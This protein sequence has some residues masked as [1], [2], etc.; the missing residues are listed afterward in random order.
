M[1]PSKIF[2]ILTLVLAA[3]LYAQ[4][5]R[6]LEQEN[7]AKTERRLALVVGNGAYRTA[8]LKNPTNDAADMARTLSEM[9]FVVIH[10]ENLNL[11][12]MKR[13]VRD[14]GARLRRD[15]GVGLFYFAGHGVQVKGRN[16][17]VPVDAEIE[18]EQEAEYESLDAGFVLAQLEDA[19]NPL[20][21]V[22]LDACRNNPFARGWRSSSTRGLAQMDAPTGTLIAYATAP[23]SIASDGAGR[24][25]LY[26]AE[27]LKQMRKP[28]LGVEEVFKQVRI[29]VRGATN[30]KQTPWESS[31]LT[32]NFYFKERAKSSAIVTETNNNPA[33]VEL[34]FW[35]SIKNSSDAEDFKEYLA[36]FPNGQFAGLARR[37]IQSLQ[38]K[39]NTGS[40]EPETPVNNASNKP[41]NLIVKARFFTF[42]LQ[43]CKISGASVNCDLLITN[44][45]SREREIEFFQLDRSPISK[46][47]DEQGNEVHIKTNSIANRRRNADATLLPGIAV[48]ATA[49]F[50]GV[51]PDSRQIKLLSLVFANSDGQTLSSFKVEY[52]NVPLTR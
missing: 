19:G 6:K 46:L 10:R 33:S 8:P 29:A 24:N 51:A 18:N 39:S 30:G 26:T 40:L 38:N 25:G 48:K 12:E 37:K 16:Y 14:F 9:G 52:R 2:L 27:L 32:G 50:E 4:S 17:L 44:D 11:N 21:I 49:T 13:A 28:N 45:E 20:N 22:I 43:Q 23:G 47:F 41:L 35:D 5:G 31:S 7:S 36:R 1:K 34:I 15:G 3:S 42:N